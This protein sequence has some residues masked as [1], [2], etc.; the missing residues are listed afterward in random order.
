MRM[1]AHHTICFSFS[2]QGS[3]LQVGFL[4]TAQTCR[5]ELQ[6]A[7]AGVQGRPEVQHGRSME[8]EQDDQTTYL[9]LLAWIMIIN[10]NFVI[11]ITGE[12]LHI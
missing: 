6:L 4:V 3:S 8:P 9:Q 2:C 11:A 10:N 7:K 1:C 12:F 5:S